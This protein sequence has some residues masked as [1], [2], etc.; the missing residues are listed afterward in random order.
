MTILHE[1]L[2]DKD[3]LLYTTTKDFDHSF[4]AEAVSDDDLRLFTKE[5]AESL[6][7]QLKEM[8]SI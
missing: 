6:I 1:I 5:D 7:K 4:F 2:F 8:F 3:D